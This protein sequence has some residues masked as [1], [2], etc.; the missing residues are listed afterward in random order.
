MEF[1][2]ENIAKILIFIG[3]LIISIIIFTLIFG[4][5]NVGKS[6]TYSNMENNLLKAATKY[7]NNN[8]KL[9]PTTEEETNK[10]NLDTLVDSRY[11]KELH[12][13]EDENVKCTGYVEL[14]YK[15]KNNIY[16]PYL[17]C[18]KYYETKTIADYIINNQQVVTSGDGLY[19]YNGKY[20]FRGENPNNYLGIGNRLYRIIEISGDKV[21]LISN[22]RLNEYL[23]WDDRYNTEKDDT[24]GINDYSKS[25]LK[26]SLNSMIENN[27]LVEDDDYNYFSSQ[28]IDKMVNHDICI[29]KRST[30]NGSIDSSNECQSIDKDQKL[31]LITVS[32]YARASIDPNCR[33]IFDKSCM[34]YNYFSQI[35]SVFRTVTATSDNSY[36]VFYI[37]DGVAELTR[38]SSTFNAN[39]VIYIDK[40]SL[41]NSGDGSFEKPYTIR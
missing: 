38:A 40:L 23:V 22:K 13:I 15:N 31:S 25:R 16:I 14:L 18:G 41:Y 19:N 34:N 6:L 33:T 28:E 9:L 32:D 17:K 8:K 21:R 4:R 1:I 24:T 37:N 12:A 5:N 10:I 29:G 36:Q 7:A 30:S 26:D 35:G 3:V 2:R 20:V 39:I 11:I 27:S